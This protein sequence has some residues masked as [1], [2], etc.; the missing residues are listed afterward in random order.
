MTTLQCAFESPR[1]TCGG[2]IKQLQ[3]WICDT[4][5]PTFTPVCDEHAHLMPAVFSVAEIDSLFRVADDGYV[6]VR[7][8][9]IPISFPQTRKVMYIR[10]K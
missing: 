9:R 8:F 2:A 1:T 6:Q 3:H 10:L 4:R 7:G 5:N